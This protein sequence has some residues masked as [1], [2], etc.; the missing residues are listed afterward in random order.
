MMH[1]DLEVVEVRHDESF[2]VWSHGYPYRT[3]R[4]HFH[5]ELELHL[6]VA[7]TGKYFVGDHIGTFAPGNLVLL[8]ANLPHNWVSD[9][10]EGEVIEQRNLVIQFEQEF[11]S[12]CMK[13]F[14]EFRQTQTL[15]DEAA[16]GVVFDQETSAAVRPWFV[17]LLHAR[18]LP[19]ITLF[20]SVLERLCRAKQRTLLASQG[21]HT[22]TSSLA[23]TRI[24]HVLTYIS[25]NLATELREAELARLAGQSVSAFSRSFRR[26]TG[27]PFVQHVNR[28]RIDLACQLLSSDELSITEACFQSGFN[29]VSNFN[30]QFRCVKGMSPSEFRDWQR[31]NAE[32]RTLTT[33]VPLSVPYAAHAATRSSSTLRPPSTAAPGS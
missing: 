28:M 16:R 13:V 10:A 33:P 19:R 27:L 31:I 5:P 25:H 18:G 21:Y 11:I 2:K 1:P 26:Y 6:I 20:L 9:V 7:T 17:Q 15:L 14:P 24:S 3:V 23:M 4:W 8:G 30:R 22:D 29:N 32:S 12:H